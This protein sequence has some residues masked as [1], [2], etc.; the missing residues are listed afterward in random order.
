MMGTAAAIDAMTDTEVLAPDPEA[1]IASLP[2]HRQRGRDVMVVVA[3]EPLS[4]ALLELA[5]VNGLDAFACETPL[6]VI[7]TLLDLGQ[8]VACAVVAASVDWGQGLAEFLADE[9][10][11]VDRVLL[12]D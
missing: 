6:D 4:G 8:R 2:L 7:Q 3:G 1:W 10:P 12:E 11:H 9:Y 5:H